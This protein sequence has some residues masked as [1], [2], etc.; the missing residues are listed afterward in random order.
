MPNLLAPELVAQLHPTK[1]EGLDVTSLTAGS[2]RIVWWLG[3]DCGHEWSTR[4]FVRVRGG[5]CTV[6]SGHTI[7]AG[8]NDLATLKPDIVEQWHPTKNGELSPQ[9]VSLYS[10]RKAWWQDEHGHEWETAICARV[11]KNGT[12]TAC[13]ICTNKQ[14]L[15]G[16]NDLATTHPAL[17][18]QWHPIKN[19]ELTPY[20]TVAGNGKKAWWQD[21][22]G[23]E[24]EAI[25]S[26]RTRGKKTGCPVCSGYHQGEARYIGDDLATQWHPVK[27]GDLKAQD[28]SR[29]SDRKV[30]WIDALGHEWEAT[31][32]SRVGGRGCGICANNVVLAGFNDLAFKRP[33]LAAEWHPVKNGNLLPSQVTASTAKKV[34]WLS[35]VCG[36]EWEAGVGSRFTGN[37]CS[38]CGNRTVLAGF[39]DLASSPRSAAF[40]AEWHPTKNLP[41]TPQEVTMASAR[42]VWWQCSRKPEHVWLMNLNSRTTSGQGCPE[43]AAHN[44]SSKPEKELYEFLASLGLNVQQTNRKLLGNH[45]ELDMYI[46]DLKF[47]IEFNGIYWHSEA[48]GKGRNYHKMKYEAA[49]AAGIQLVQIWE[50]DWRDRKPAVMRALAHKLGVT[51]M[52]AQVHP[53]LADV[54][55]KV[56]ARKTKVVLLTTA[57]AQVFLDANHIQGFASGSYYLGLEGVDGVL[58]AVMVLKREADAV[59][60]I[61]RYATAGSVTGGFTK[62]LSHATKTYSPSSFITF[63]DH[64]I[65]DGGLY[66]KHGFVVDKLIAPDYMYVVRNERKHKFGY[67]LK[68]F[69]NDPNLL[70]EEGLTERELA[71]LNNLHRIWDA[72]K[73]RYRLVINE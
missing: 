50:D 44:F 20:G 22:H 9:Q 66:E 72:G 5:G 26:N 73:T 23:H 40:L 47:G 35:A 52:L 48:Q 71:A 16:F 38:V 32:S 37:G 6:C 14:V 57:Q 60:N 67:R 8:F 18:A 33:D 51:S 68:K 25:I 41:L 69:R 17:A 21:E 55:S 4:V 2:N 54:T 34:W 64:T 15:I 46:P 59:L 10:N 58:R 11:K 1:N 29:G 30:W 24:W 62:L 13:P 12:I 39:N 28:V 31:V 43:C 70:W 45:L 63:A 3:E 61:V 42:K 56:F 7:L 49:T 19:E 65:S 36:H 53:E 27:N